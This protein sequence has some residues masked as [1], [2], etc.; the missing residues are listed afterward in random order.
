WG[1]RMAKKAAG[2]TARE[3]ET[4]KT[5]GLRADGGGLYLQV[6]PSGAKTWIFRFQLRGRRRD[7]GL[8]SAAIFSLA[9]ARRKAADARKLVAEGVDPIE[10]RAAEVA[11]AAA[12]TAKMTPF[13][14]C[15]KQYVASHEVGWRNAKHRKQW[16]STLEMYVYPVIG[17]API[18][19]ID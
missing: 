5:P 6:A 16:T 19:T 13:K 8:G 4:V 14:E 15:A 12:E 1:G 2:L 10:R 3:V 17:T 18:G 11:A 9:E 7:M